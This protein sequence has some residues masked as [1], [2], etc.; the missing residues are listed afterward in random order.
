[1]KA[2]KLKQA[3]FYNVSAKERPSLNVG[4]T[5]RLKPD[6]RSDWL[7]KGSIS[8]MLPYRSYEVRPQDGTTTSRTSK[9]D[10]LKNLPVC[11]HRAGCGS[12]TP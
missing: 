1:M 10:S 7:Q 8:K 9:H 6:D 3:A 12:H 11:V 5:V 4:Q 2:V